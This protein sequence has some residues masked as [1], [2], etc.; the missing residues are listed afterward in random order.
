MHA[1]THTHTHTNKHIYTNYIY[2]Y[3]DNRTYKI[4]AKEE[5]LQEKVLD[6]MKAEQISNPEKY[7]I[8]NT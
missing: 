1:H 7:Q 4:N 8:I 3:T 6:A 5:S 2:T